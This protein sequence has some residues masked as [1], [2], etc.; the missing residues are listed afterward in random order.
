MADDDWNDLIEEA[1]RP[2]TFQA[3]YYGRC[4]DGCGE[5]INPGD[6]VC[7]NRANELVHEEC[8]D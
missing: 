8:Y 5:K 3:E 2:H 6:M 7:Y 1:E 4:Y